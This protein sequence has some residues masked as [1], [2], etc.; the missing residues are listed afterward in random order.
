MRGEWPLRTLKRLRSCPDS[1]FVPPPQDYF[2]NHYPPAP[3]TPA[4]SSSRVDSLPSAFSNLFSAFDSPP[5]APAASPSDGGPRPRSRP[6]PP[7]PPPPPPAPAS[8]P[9]PADFRPPQRQPPPPP[10]SPAPSPAP[11]RTTPTTS[12]AASP[13]TRLPTLEELS[14]AP[15]TLSV[16]NVRT[17][18]ARTWR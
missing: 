4:P 11:S 16:L 17:L 13:S 12:S 18:K 2:R 6:S 8:S 7:P 15:E 5:S 14:D 10:H 9:R 1:P 3:Q